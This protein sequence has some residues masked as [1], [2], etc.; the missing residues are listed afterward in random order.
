MKGGKNTRARPGRPEKPIT[1]RDKVSASRKEAVWGGGGFLELKDRLLLPKARKKG[2]AL[3]GAK[4]AMKE[5]GGEKKEGGTLKGPLLE[6]GVNTAGHEKKK[7]R[8]SCNLT[9]RKR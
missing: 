1:S 3:Q 7:K 2:K 4:S 6:G 9:S 8:N 5:K